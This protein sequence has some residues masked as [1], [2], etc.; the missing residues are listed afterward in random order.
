MLLPVCMHA[1]VVGMRQALEWR[2]GATDEGV[3]H[4]V[5]VGDAW[6]CGAGMD[7]LLVILEVRRWSLSGSGARRV[8]I[9]ETSI[10]LSAPPLTRHARAW[11]R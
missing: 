10:H 3:T 2:S 1:R 11:G 6:I 8:R 5:G 4:S 9:A 7:G